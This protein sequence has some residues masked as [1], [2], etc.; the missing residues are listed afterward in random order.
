MQI[1]NTGSDDFET[2]S[3]QILEGLQQQRSELLGTTIDIHVGIGLL[4]GIEAGRLAQKYGDDDA[5]VQLLRDRGEVVAAR[6]EALSVEHEIAVVRTPPPPATRPLLHG[7]I[8]DVPQAAAGRVT[9]L[10]IGEKGQPVAGVDPVETDDTGYFAF[11]L[12]AE[13]VKAISGT[14]LSVLLRVADVQLAPAAA[15]P[16]TVAPGATLVMEVSLSSTELERLRLRIPVA[17]E[18]VKVPAD[19]DKN[20]ADKAAVDKSTADEAADKAAGDKTVADKEAVEKAA[21]AETPVAAKAAADEAA[22]D[23]MT[24]DK[25]A[26]DKKAASKSATKPTTQGG[27]TGKKR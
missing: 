6:V 25:T 26:A 4:A 1:F 16:V 10:L 9:V 18:M 7:R 24:A 2:A 21:A 19:D 13:T 5:R 17:G 11:E 22:T 8:T 15:E 12:K 23:K 27:S 20:A 14:K 3:T